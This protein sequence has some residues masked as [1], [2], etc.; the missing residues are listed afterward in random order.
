MKKI[1]LL[2]AALVL[3]ACAEDTPTTPPAEARAVASFPARLSKACDNGRARLYDECGSQAAVLASALAEGRR[4]GKTVLVNFGAEWCIWCHVF[5]AH[6]RGATGRF[7]YPVDGESV[8]LVERSG[9]G[10]LP[11][12]G[13]LNAYAAANFVLAHIEL[14]KAPDGWDVMDATGSR[15]AYAEEYPYV[16]A[17]T[18][19]GRFAAAI[20]T[21]QAEV[22]RDNGEDWYRGYDRP[23]LLGELKRARQTAAAR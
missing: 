14:E 15:Q 10:V 5:D 22:R 3:A 8:L 23:H 11:Q 16:V 1:W 18:P 21:K 4:S 20:D 9:R 12:A 7:D 13:R 19:D 6:L 2:G 17:L